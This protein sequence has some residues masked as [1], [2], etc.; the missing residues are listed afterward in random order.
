MLGALRS[1]MPPETFCEVL[2][3]SPFVAETWAR[4]DELPE[5]QRRRYWL[6]INPFYVEE[7]Q[8]TEAM[9]RLAA[10]ERPRAALAVG[11]IFLGRLEP[12][13]LYSLL[14]QIARAP[15]PEPGGHQLEQ[16]W[17]FDAFERLNAASDL[18]VEQKAFLEFAYIDAL[19]VMRQEGGDSHLVP[20]LERYLEEHPEFYVQAL[21]RAFKRRDEGEDRSRASAE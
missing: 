21:V 1:A 4:V 18:T 10:A 13:F 14:S 6:E 7:N 2:K 12:T 17:I 19:W 11:H 9:T 15:H 3:L 20:N 5:P 16:H 8:V